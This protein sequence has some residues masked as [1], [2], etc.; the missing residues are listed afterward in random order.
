[1]KDTHH[2]LKKEGS[3]ESIDC[4]PSPRLESTTA[5]LKGEPSPMKDTHHSVES[6]T[7]I[8]Y[9]N[10]GRTHTDETDIPANATIRQEYVKCGNPD[11]QNQMTM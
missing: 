1:M 10:F 11:C 2:S 7:R 6:K 4:R 8:A 3:S 9:M 5:A